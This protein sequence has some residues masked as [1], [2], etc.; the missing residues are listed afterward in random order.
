ML[1]R[2]RRQSEGAASILGKVL[3]GFLI[4]LFLGKFFT[5]PAFRRK[6]T[7]VILVAG[8]VFV[9]G[10]V[11]ALIYVS[12]GDIARSRE[13]RANFTVAKEGDYAMSDMRVVHNDSGMPFLSAAGTITNKTNHHWEY[14]TFQIKYTNADGQEHQQTKELNRGKAITVINIPAGG[15]AAFASDRLF[16]NLS[17][18]S[19]RS[20]QVE[21][22]DMRYQI[23]D[24]V[25]SLDKDLYAPGEDIA[26]TVH[27]IINQEIINA[28]GFI[29]IYEV[30][31]GVGPGWLE[32]HDLNGS[33]G[34][35][36]FTAPNTD[37][38]Y[39]MR[40]Y[41]RLQYYDATIYRTRFAVG[42]EPE[43]DSS[44]TE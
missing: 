24:F 11:C 39:E 33:D 8:L 18:E 15:S 35:F 16:P 12:R 26:A 43:Q 13:R 23:T 41:N 9:V 7:K 40:L 1:R 28:G 31:S 37:G 27:G 2:N 14:V 29:A 4:G 17:M 25:I 10:I 36:R 6:S 32:R 34:S 19:V 30:G 22:F 21:Y 38:N 20:T 3:G 44:Q 5:D 42:T